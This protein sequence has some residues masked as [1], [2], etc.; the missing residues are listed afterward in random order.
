[1][2][3][4]LLPRDDWLLFFYFASYNIYFTPRLSLTIDEWRMRGEKDGESAGKG[5]FF[6]RARR[7]LMFMI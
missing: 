7:F 2:F 1:M 6:S 4:F 5:D 3:S